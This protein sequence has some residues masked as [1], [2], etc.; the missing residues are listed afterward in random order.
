MNK[1]LAV[2][3]MGMVSLSGA[4]QAQVAPSVE[5]NRQREIDDKQRQQEVVDRALEQQKLRGQAGAATPLPAMPQQIPQLGGETF[6]IDRIVIVNDPLTAAASLPLIASL[7]HSRI[8]AS[9]IFGLI[10]GL[11]DYYAAQGYSTTSVSVGQ[12]N[13]KSGT[14]EFRVN[15]GYVKGVLIDGKPVAGWRERAM[16]ATAMP[17]IAGRI[18]NIHDVD[19]MVENLSTASKTAKVVI[20]AAEQ[21]GYSYLN[22]TFEHRR[23]VGL[24]G[25][26]D[27]SNQT[28]A[29]ARAKFGATLS[30]SDALGLNDTMALSWGRGGYHHAGDNAQQNWG[31]SYAMPIGYWTLNVNVSD[32]RYDKWLYGENGRYESNGVSTDSRMRTSYLLSRDQTGKSTAWLELDSKGNLNY[33]ADTLIGIS[34]KRYSSATVGW[35]RTDSLWGGVANGEL[36][37]TRGGGWFGGFRGEGDPDEPQALYTKLNGSFTW[38]RSVNAFGVGLQYVGRAAGQYSQDSLLSAN[39]LQIGDEFTVRGFIA[40]PLAGDRGGYLSNTLSLPLP[41]E[42]LMPWLRSVVP[43]VGLDAGAAR[44]VLGKTAWG[45]VVGAAVGVKVGM[46]AADLSLMVG[47]PLHSSVSSS[48]KPVAYLSLNWQL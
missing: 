6:L 40:D 33:L 12:Q 42:R 24:S 13:L 47:R 28:D 17:G 41:N 5:A 31:L 27:N 4:A 26:V 9:E 23:K 20:E 46:P 30:V 19:Q 45:Y 16:V 34:S 11:T 43:V 14:L 38:Q 15:W 25:T 35:T 29:A 36:S 21:D 48:T 32:Y 2:S 37:L 3:I 1:F 39:A 18:L 10:K 7:E 8:G 44:S 22:L